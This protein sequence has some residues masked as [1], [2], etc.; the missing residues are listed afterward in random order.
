MTTE[1]YLKAGKFAALAEKPKALILDQIPDK[2][3]YDTLNRIID[4]IKENN[5]SLEQAD[6]L[7]EMVRGRIHKIAVI[8]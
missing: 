8:K 4:V 6:L 2:V 5:L 1:E 3:V 7:L